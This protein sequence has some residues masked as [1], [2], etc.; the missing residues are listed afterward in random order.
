MAYTLTYS[1][2]I[3]GWPS[4]YSYEPE[5]MIGMNNYFYS[6]KGGELYRHNTNTI[7]NRFYNIDYKSSITGVINDNPSLVKTFKTINIESNK[8]WNCTLDSDLDSGYIDR[9]WFSL[10]EGEYFAYIRRR[11]GETSLDLRSRQGIGSVDSVDSSILSAVVLG[12]T[13]NIDSI[14][15]VGDKIYTINSSLIGTITS[16]SSGEITVDTTLELDPGVIPVSGDYI[17]CIKN[18]VAES[19]GTTG[20]YLGYEIELPV[21]TASS[22]TEIY[23]I[24]SN[25]FKSY[26]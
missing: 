25:L 10:K 14:I 19:Y 23:S 9:D 16:V 13:F 3:K 21:G 4:F 11:E 24:G 20:Y 12:F 6:F 17:M 1:D 5:A 2:S 15:S 18:S 22:F 26:P 8:P 7:R